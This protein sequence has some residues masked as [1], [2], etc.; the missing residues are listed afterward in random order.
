MLSLG[1]K[2]NRTD[3]FSASALRFLGWGAAWLEAQAHPL[4]L[5]SP[6]ITCMW[7]LLPVLSEISRA[8]SLRSNT[9]ISSFSASAEALGG[10]SPPRARRLEIREGGIPAP[11]FNVDP[12]LPGDLLDNTSFSFS[13]TRA[14]IVR[15][16]GRR[17]SVPTA[18][19]ALCSPS[20][21]PVW[22]ASPHRPRGVGHEAS[23]CSEKWTQLQEGG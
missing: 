9:S 4:P 6:R 13:R 20:G 23:F 21:K 19:R 12:A 15:C 17:H 22:G 3:P 2:C 7:Q 14:L 8:G 11:P 1:S 16:S 5:H 18:W 10:P